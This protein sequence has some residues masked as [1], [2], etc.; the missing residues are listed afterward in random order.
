MTLPGTRSRQLFSRT[1]I[2]NFVGCTLMVIGMFTTPVFV[3]VG[4]AV[5]LASFSV[6][7]YALVTSRRSKPKTRL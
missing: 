1:I 5:L 4:F 6:R 3:G 2:A 7:L